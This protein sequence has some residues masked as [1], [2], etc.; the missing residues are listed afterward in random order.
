VACPPSMG[1]CFQD[2]VRS[3]EPSPAFWVCYT[4]SASAQP[5]SRTTQ[6]IPVLQR[7]ADTEPTLSSAC[8]P[9]LGLW[10]RQTI[11]PWD[12]QLAVTT[13]QTECSRRLIKTDEKCQIGRASCRER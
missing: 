3:G 6:W 7:A 8:L 2:W 12:S 4:L 13:L 11:V 5:P 9:S 1:P 10:L